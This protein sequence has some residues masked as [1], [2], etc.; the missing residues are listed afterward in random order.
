MKVSN[1]VFEDAQCRAELIYATNWAC[2]LHEVLKYQDIIFISAAP[3]SIHECVEYKIKDGVYQIPY[4]LHCNPLL[5]RNRSWI[6]TIHKDKIFWKNLL[7]K[8]FLAS[9][10]WVKNIQTAG[11]NGAYTVLKRKSELN[12]IPTGKG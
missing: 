1:I 3:N 10:K 7:E 11:Y 6:I 8:T 12:P 4:T 5:I 2:A 9:K